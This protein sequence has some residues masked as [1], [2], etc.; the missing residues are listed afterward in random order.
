MT[1]ILTILGVVLILEGLPYFAFPGKVKSWALMMQDL[2]DR[3]LRIIGL[4]SVAAGFIVLYAIRY[5]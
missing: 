5:L 4:V 3:S 1:F 2:P